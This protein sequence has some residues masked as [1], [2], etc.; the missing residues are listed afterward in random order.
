MLQMKKL[1]RYVDK[2]Y[3]KQLLLLLLLILWASV[4]EVVSIG[5]VLP[6]LGVITAPEQVYQHEFMQPV[7]DLLGVTSPDQLLLP[8]TMVFIFAAIIAGGTRLALVYVMTRLS[9]SIGSDLSVNMYRRTLYQEYSV[10]VSRNSSEVINGIITKTNIVIGRIIS[11]TLILISSVILIHAIMFILLSID[12]VVASVASVGFGSLYFFVVFYN[13]QKLQ[14]NS[15]CIASQSDQMVKAIQEGLGG[16][17]DV[18]IDRSQK[19]YCK[20]YKEADISMRKAAGSNAFI[21]QSPR[22]IME[23]I[24]MSLIAG[25]AYFMVLQD[26]NTAAVVPVLGT[27]ALGAQRLLPILQQIYSSYSSI[28]GSYASLYD[29]LDLLDQ[30]LPDFSSSSNLAPLTFDR[31]IELNNVSF[32]YKYN[33]PWILNKINL[34]IKK[35][36]RIGFIGVTGSGKSTL[37]DIIMGLLVPVKGKMLVDGVYVTEKNRVLWRANIA[38]VP[39][40]VYLSDGTIKENIAFGVPKEHIDFNEIKK[41]TQQAQLATLIEEWPEKYQTVVGERGVRLSGGQR[42]RIGIAR[43]LYKGAN[44]LIFDEATSALDNETEQAVMESIEVLGK[45]ITILIIAHRLTTL[46]KC[47]KV[48]ELSK[49]KKLYIDSYSNIINRKNNYGGLS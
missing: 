7:K 13:R 34:K 32:R 18:I 47:D 27:L 11:P 4:V 9:Q 5:A 15:K 36:E 37:L 14:E 24:G 40:S 19:F 48:V 44:V 38:H 43:A 21:E 16:I 17:R 20:L 45:G 29:V 31:E 46:R 49:N 42:Q 12:T 3:Q 35:G 26:E 30:T 2:R 23:A 33:S 8:F 25:L 1:W 41:A 22:F 10:H 39:Q 6:F 28:K